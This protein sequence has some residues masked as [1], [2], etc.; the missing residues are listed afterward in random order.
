MN[1]FITLHREELIQSIIAFAA[2]LLLGFILK[3]GVRKVGKTSLLNHT[4]TML[5]IKYVDAFTTIAILT[6]AGFIWSVNFTDISLIFSS[7]FAVLGVALF[8]QWSILSNVTSGVILFF[9]FPFKIGDRIEIMDSGFPSEAVIE[10][11]RAFHIHLRTDEGRLITYPNNLLLQK[12]VIVI[13]NS[14]TG[15][16]K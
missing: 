16:D 7:V 3:K 13:N 14:K 11:I 1:G 15:S 12:G 4:R 8:A 2:L 9:S 10:D 6:S 5:I